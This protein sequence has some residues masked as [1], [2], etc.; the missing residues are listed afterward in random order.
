MRDH[1][2]QVRVARAQTLLVIFRDLRAVC[3]VFDKDVAVLDRVELLLALN[4]V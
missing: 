2:W 1:V 4:L 3:G